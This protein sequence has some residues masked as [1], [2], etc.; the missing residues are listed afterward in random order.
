MEP[1]YSKQE[2]LGRNFDFSYRF[3]YRFLNILVHNIKD[4]CNI[5]VS[6]YRLQSV[7]VLLANWATPNIQRTILD[8]VGGAESD[9]Q[10]ANRL[11]SKDLLYITPFDSSS[12]A[13]NIPI[14]EIQ[15][16]MWI[17][18]HLKVNYQAIE[19]LSEYYDVIIKNVDFA[20][21]TTKTII[22]SAVEE[23]THGLIKE[24]EI[25]LNPNTQAL[26]TDFIYFKARWT[27]SFDEDRTEDHFFYGTKGKK[28]VPM[29]ER[30]GNMSYGET[31]TC[32]MVSLQY[33]CESSESLL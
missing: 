27:E 7:L 18:Q 22:D 10:E 33:K 19:N 23:A 14:I 20:D 21:S 29:M 2:I 26:L 25:V 9:I 3:N 8:V 30:I 13:Q 32:Q 1:V 28:K 16:L 24:L 4:D 15:T 12:L 5:S 17:Q 11:C 6:S 31:E